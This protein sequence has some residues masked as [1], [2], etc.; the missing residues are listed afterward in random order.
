MGG[1]VKEG[2]NNPLWLPFIKGE[3]SLRK[4]SIGGF[5]MIHGSIVALVT[6][7]KNGNIDEDTLKDLI[8]FQ[9][10]NGTH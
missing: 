7:F 1:A 10:E 9:I 4:G 6:P 5:S 2:R 3:E 8:E